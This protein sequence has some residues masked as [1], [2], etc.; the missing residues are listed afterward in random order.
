MPPPVYAATDYLAQFQKLLPRGR[1]WHR[2]WGWIQDADLLALMPTWARLNTRLNDLIAELFPCST[3]ELI[4]EWEDSLGLPGPCMG[5]LPT[6]QQRRQAICAKFVARGAQTPAYFVSLANS[7]GYD[8]EVVQ[9]AP[10]RCG[11]NRCGDPLYGEAWAYAWVL[12][13]P[14]DIVIIDFQVGISTAG[15]PLRT[16]G[17]KRLLCLLLRD[18]PAHTVFILQYRLTESLWDLGGSIWDGGASIWDEGVL[19]LVPPTGGGLL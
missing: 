7:L 3:T 10:F 5:P 19:A 4:P 1:I 2:G 12:I 6:T 15:D 14:S 18:M 17:D 8:A 11:F 9:F 13:L 16:W